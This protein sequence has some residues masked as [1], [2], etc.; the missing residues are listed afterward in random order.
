MQRADA[1]GPAGH[2]SHGRSDR[3]LLALCPS[4]A[5]VA[6]MLPLPQQLLVLTH[7]GPTARRLAA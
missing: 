6:G 5:A 1:W 4:S 2:Y 3:M 7:V